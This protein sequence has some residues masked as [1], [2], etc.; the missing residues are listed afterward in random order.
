MPY[1]TNFVEEHLTDARMCKVNLD[2][3][4]LA[5]ISKGTQPAMNA[6]QSNTTQAM[7]DSESNNNNPTDNPVAQTV[8]N[9]QQQVA[10]RRRMFRKDHQQNK[11][12]R[13]G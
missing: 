12:A 8:Q 6:E 9:G 10:K 2:Y 7:I 4:W 3:H 1:Q 5:N 11:G 13:K